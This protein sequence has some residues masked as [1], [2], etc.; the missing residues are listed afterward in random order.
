MVLGDVVYKLVAMV[1]W[2][3][4]HY[5]TQLLW[6]GQGWLTYD[7]LDGGELMWASR[8]H[9]PSSFDRNHKSGQQYTATYVRLPAGYRDKDNHEGTGV[10]FTISND[11]IDQP[12]HIK[13]AKQLFRTGAGW[14]K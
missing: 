3:G 8:Q 1:Y 7:D 4:T 5:T 13:T 14:L 12:V 2:S 6:N 11:V 9:G 10:R